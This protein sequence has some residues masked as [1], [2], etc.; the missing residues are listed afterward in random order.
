MPNFRINFLSISLPRIRK[1]HKDLPGLPEPKYVGTELIFRLKK[2]H[3]YPRTQLSNKKRKEKRANLCRRK[4]RV[5]PHHP[6]KSQVSSARA[7]NRASLRCTC[8]P[9]GRKSLGAHAKRASKL[10]LRRGFSGDSL[11]GCTIDF[12][13]IRIHTGA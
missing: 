9:R 3:C 11:G 10:L 2:T 12:R 8:L 6:A 4:S 7:N 1:N 13:Y 5:K